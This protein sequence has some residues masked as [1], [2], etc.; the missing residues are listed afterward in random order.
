MVNLLQHIYT[1]LSAVTPLY[2]EKA[3]EGTPMPYATY[4]LGLSG[5][6]YDREDIPL[7]VDLWDNKPDTTA[8]DTLGQTVKD[9]LNNH[10]YTDANFGVTVYLTGRFNVPD[11]EP[12]IRHR[13][14]TFNLATYI[15]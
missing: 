9:T 2:Y 13:Q 15:K 12:T 5:D 7:V 6:V 11:P 3:P 10:T 4:T 14:L 8:L 1:I